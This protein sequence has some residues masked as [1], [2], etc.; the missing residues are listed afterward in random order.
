MNL[1]LIDKHTAIINDRRRFP[2][3]STYEGTGSG[4]GLYIVKSMVEELGGTIRVNS[5]LNVGTT[6]TIALKRFG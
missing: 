3:S 4:I 6:F 2:A 5:A 1:N